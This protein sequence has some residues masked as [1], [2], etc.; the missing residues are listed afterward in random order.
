MKLI[1]VGASGYIGKQLYKRS[2]K[3]FV[4]YGTSSSSNGE[5]LLLKLEEPNNFNYE[6]IQP[7]DVVCLTA[8][9][10]A[11]DTCSSDHERAWA[12]NVTGTVEFITKVMRRGG[13]VIFFSSDMVYGEKKDEFDESAICH[14]AGEYAF[15]KHEVEKKFSNEVLFKSIRLSYVFSKEDNF[16][17]YLVSCAQRKEEA[18]IF[19]P[20]YRSIIHRDD[21]VDGVIALSQRWDDFPQ[22]IFNFSG[23]NILARIDFATILQKSVLPNLR[24]HVS[25]PDDGFFENRPR[26]IS[27]KS[28]ILKTLFNRPRHALHEAAMI[29]FNVEGV[30]KND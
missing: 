1:I 15:M 5:L 23:P 28:S 29:E 17:K 25:E 26:I 11:P 14:P 22:S 8:A 10:S 7:L 30:V 20:F 18:D 24:F 27:M 9:I 21:V 19:H 2:K 6:V 16:T 12:I 3:L 4:T 13:R